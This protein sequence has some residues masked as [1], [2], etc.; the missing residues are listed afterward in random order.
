M[1]TAG[2]PIFI[3][4]APFSGASF[5]AAVLGSHPQLYAVPELNLF[6][7]DRVGELLGI[8]A[9][10]QGTH[11]QGLLRAVAELECGGQS[12]AGVDGARAWLRARADWPV[13]GLLDALVA[14]VAPR[15]LFVPDTETPLRA[16][17]LCRLRAAAPRAQLVQLLRHP[18]SACAAHA[19]W[20]RE[21]LFVPADFKDHSTRPPLL[22]PQLGWFRAHR[23]IERHWPS[24][25]RLRVE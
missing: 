16:A 17:D 21:R 6:M 13:A 15:R 11:G 22:D 18:Y 23:T 25:L 7:A 8:Y 19:A 4:A 24:A 12:D 2:D 14:R 1:S 20:L 10:G 5:L 3:L 9:A